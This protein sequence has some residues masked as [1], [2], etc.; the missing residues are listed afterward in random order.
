MSI[1]NILNI[2]DSERPSN[3]RKDSEEDRLFGRFIFPGL[4]FMPIADLVDIPVI[5]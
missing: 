2:R 4:E 5:G 3:F 1:E